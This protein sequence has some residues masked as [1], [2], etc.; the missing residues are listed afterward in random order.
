MKTITDTLIL[1]EIVAGLDPCDMSAA[2]GKAYASYEDED[3]GILIDASVRWYGGF[4]DHF[5]TLEPY[6]IVEIDGMKILFIGILTEEVMNSASTEKIVGSLVDISDAAK[7]I[8]KICNAFNG[9]DIDFTVL[10][11]H[12]GFEKDKELAASLNPDLGIDVIIGGHPHVVQPVELLTSAT[13]PEHKTVCLYSMGNAVSNQRLGNLTA[14]QTAH[15][16]DGVLF[17]VTFEKYSDGTVYLAGVDLIPTWVNLHYPN[18]GAEYAILPLDFDRVEEWKEMFNINEATV[19]T[20]RNSYSRTMAIVGAG[21]E[22]SQTYLAR[23][24]EDR[25]E[26]YYNL[27]WHPEMF[28]TQPVETVPETFPE[29]TAAAA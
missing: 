21:L 24:K 14:I 16:E 27:A 2:T 4:V 8:E 23:A 15:T 28:E 18:G 22:A 19:S 3:N 9:I 29:E 11:T 1:D 5:I 7:E 6:H 17:S 25:D 12:I 20:A 26:Y 13:D 10:L